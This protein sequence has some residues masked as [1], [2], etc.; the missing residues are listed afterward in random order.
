MHGL[1]SLL[2]QPYYNQVLALWDEL[3]SDFRLKGIRVTPFPH[4]SWEIAEEYDEA[5]LAQLLNEMVL[6]LPPLHVTCT[7]LGIFSGPQPVIF[8]PVVKTASL[9]QLHQTVWDI[10]KPA[11]KDRSPYYSPDF[12]MP[13]ISLAYMDVTPAN[14]GPLMEKLAFRSFNWQFEVDNF[15]YIYEPEGS[16]GQIKLQA[17][18]SGK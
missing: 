8:I 17:T 1:V 3:E 5:L 9:V 10:L 18:W 12:W 15:T 2:P 16:I 7:G 14:I 6:N 11:A 13:H 4:F